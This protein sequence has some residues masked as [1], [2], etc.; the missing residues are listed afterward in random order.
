MYIGFANGWQETGTSTELSFA[1]YCNFSI[2]AVDPIAN[3]KLIGTN[4][5]EPGWYAL[6]VNQLYRRDGRYAFFTRLEPVDS[7][8]YS[9]YI[10]K[11]SGE[12][13][14]PSTNV[15]TSL[16]GKEQRR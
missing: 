14:R 2:S 6:S 5:I 10:Y 3:W 11:V 9:T 8:G 16:A 13:L 12:D 4:A 7:V 1:P 15:A